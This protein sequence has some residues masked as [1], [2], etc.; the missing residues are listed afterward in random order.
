M[1][2]MHDDPATCLLIN[3]LNYFMEKNATALNSRQP[4]SQQAGDL[5]VELKSQNGS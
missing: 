2:S 4:C 3:P 5:I 1:K